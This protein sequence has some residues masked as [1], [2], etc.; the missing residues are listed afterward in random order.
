MEILSIRIN[1]Q[2]GIKLVK[3]SDDKRKAALKNGQREENKYI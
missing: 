2:A 1:R 3:I